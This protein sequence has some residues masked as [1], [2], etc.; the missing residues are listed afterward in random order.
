MYTDLAEKV[1][2]RRIGRNIREGENTAELILAKPELVFLNEEKEKQ[3][4]ALIT[5]KLQPDQFAAFASHDLCEPLHTISNCM[6]V[7]EEDYLDELDDTARKCI[8]SAHEAAKRMN[9]LIAALSDF[10]CLGHHVYFTY[11][12]CAVLIDEVIADLDVE[13]K[14]SNAII[15]VT[16]MPKLYLIEPLIRQLF[17]NLLANA[18]KFRKKGSQPKIKISS[19]QIDENWVFLVTDHGIGIAPEH[20]ERIFEIFQRVQADEKEYKGHGTGLAICEKIVHLHKGEIWVESTIGAGSTFYFTLP[21][22]M[23]KCE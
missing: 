17:Q 5:S 19:E 7:F 13:I 8:H 11:S 14:T 23:Q 9:I 4:A 21:D 1:K 6:H 22:S 12:D 2:T 20:F 16:A 15:E 18:I 10:S 3:V